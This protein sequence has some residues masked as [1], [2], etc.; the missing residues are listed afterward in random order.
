[1]KKS[2]LIPILLVFIFSCSPDEETQAPTNTVQTTTPEKVAVQYT[3]TVTSANGGSVTD[4]GTYDDGTELTITATP[5]EGYEFVGWEGNDSS[6]SSLTITLN[7]NQTV[8]PIFQIIQYTLSVSTTEG[9]T[10]SSEGG[11]YDFGTEVTITAT[12]NE[13][14]RFTGWEG[15]DSSNSDLTITLNSNQIITANFVENECGDLGDLELY[16]CEKASYLQR[17]NG[18]YIISDSQEPNRTPDSYTSALE[19]FEKTVKIFGSLL[20]QNND[21]QIDENNLSINDAL[22]NYMVMVIGNRS[23]VDQITNKIRSDFSPFYGMGMFTEDWPTS[24]SFNLNNVG[25]STLSTSLWRPSNFCA[26]YEESFHTITEAMNRIDEE[27]S[28]DQASVLGNFMQDDIDNG[29]YDISVQNEIEGGNYGF[30]TAVNELLHQVW[31]IYNAEL[32][33]ILTDN[34]TE[35]LNFMIEKNVPMN[36]NIDYNH[37]LG[38]RLK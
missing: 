30:D 16:L 11:T 22:S 32:T 38:V 12:P 9:G 14:Y 18:F 25:L 5:N 3:L 2:I 7:S 29:L 17:I 10:V 28:F 36:L 6:N 31:I 35:M 20:D 1:M 24:T 19:V 4:G 37:Q 13:G 34:Q 21:G 23:F 33:S 8:Q 27:F 15:K 26:L